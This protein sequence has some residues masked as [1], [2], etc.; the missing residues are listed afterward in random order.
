MIERYITG[1]ESLV[2]V[3]PSQNPQKLLLLNSTMVEGWTRQH[4]DIVIDYVRSHRKESA[5]KTALSVFNLFSC[6]FD[7]EYV[8]RQV[9]YWR[10][11]F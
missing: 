2:P 11:Y 6:E 3:A 9:K 4:D 7:Y 10:W 5:E 1:D 8:C